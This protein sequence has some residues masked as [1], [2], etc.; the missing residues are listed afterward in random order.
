[1]L[2]VKTMSATLEQARSAKHLAEEAFA[3]LADVVGIGITRASE[4]Y[5]VKVNLRHPPAEGV[6]LPKE[7]N[8]VPVKVE[9][10]GTI[11]K[12]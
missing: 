8:G 7:V 3:A 4:G 9:V 5:A 10:V 2:R 6:D 12:R 11:S 1:L